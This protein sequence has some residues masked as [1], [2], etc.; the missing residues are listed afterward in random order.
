MLACGSVSH[1]TRRACHGRRLPRAHAAQAC[2]LTSRA[3]NSRNAFATPRVASSP[4]SRARADAT[5]VLG[6]AEEVHG[7][8]VGARLEDPPSRAGLALFRSATQ[9]RRAAQDR[10]LTQ[11][12]ASGNRPSGTFS[13]PAVGPLQA[14]HAIDV[15]CAH[16]VERR[17][18][19]RVLQ[20]AACTWTLQ[21]RPNERPRQT[22]RIASAGRGALI[23]ILDI[24]SGNITAEEVVAMSAGAGCQQ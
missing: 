22:I 7:L 8:R 13:T 23:R 5:S 4:E 14:G 18:W 3:R 16:A 12:L 1:Q 24:E 21:T 15:R 10:A 2:E 19:D 9:A 11:D 20:E 6:H 17:R